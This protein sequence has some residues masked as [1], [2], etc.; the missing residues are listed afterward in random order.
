VFANTLV[1]VET[2]SKVVVCPL[3]SGDPQVTLSHVECLPQA[4]AL[5]MTRPDHLSSF[6]PRSTRVALRGSCRPSTMPLIKLFSGASHK[7]LMGFNGDHA[8]KTSRRCQPLRVTSTTGMQLNHLMPLDAIT[9][10]N[11]LEITHFAIGSHSCKH[12]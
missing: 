11:A 4:L 5:D 2:S 9:Q 6:A 10:C 8:T 1:P 3:A 12:K 7:L